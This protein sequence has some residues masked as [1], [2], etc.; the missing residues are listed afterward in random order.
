MIVRDL[1]RLALLAGPFLLLFLLSV[2]LWQSQN[3]D[4]RSR[5]GALFDNHGLPTDPSASTSPRAPRLTPNKTHYQVFSQSSPDGEFF[6]IRF[7]EDALNPNILPHPKFNNTWYIVA[8][9]PPKHEKGSLEID[10]EEVGC[11][12]QFIKGALMCIDPAQ[13][14]PYEPTPGGNCQGEIDFFNLNIGPR[15]ARVFFG[16][17]NI[18]TVFASNSA[19]TCFGQFIQDFRALVDWYPKWMTKAIDA[20]FSVGTEIERP[21][22][23]A[24]MEKDYFIFWDKDDAMHV[25]YD[26]FPQRGYA[27]LQPDG[28]TGPELA[29]E[30]AERDAKCLRRYLPELVDNGSESIRQA[31][32]S[33]RVTLCESVDSTCEPRDDN[34]YIM[35]VIHHKTDLAFHSEYEPYVV[36]FQQRAPYELYAVSRRPFWISGRTRRGDG[37]P[38]DAVSITSANWRDRGRN[39]H[40]FL[41][42]VIM[43]GFQYGERHSAGIDVR[44]GDLLVDLGLCKDAS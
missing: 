32:N 17:Q 29:S 11:V 44:A 43:L 19:F 2:S 24:P 28:K 40:G 3:D 4:L 39:Y 21:F 31:T 35:T 15:D 42:D 5:V 13:P 38:T 30:T 36:L 10:V 26:M 6:D 25:H 8:Q 37:L 20:D 22:P 1:K 23:H 27:K 7:D 12:A 18:W 33:L 34:T 14:L 9:L 16:P 41:D